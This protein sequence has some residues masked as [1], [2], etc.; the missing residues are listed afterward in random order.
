MSPNHRQRHELYRMETRLQA[1]RDF[2]VPPPT[3][4]A[5]PIR[6]MT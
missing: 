3:S 4:D 5:G 2:Q 1:Y 6:R